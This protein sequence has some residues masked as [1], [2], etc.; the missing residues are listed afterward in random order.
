MVIFQNSKFKIIE[1]LIKPLSRTP[2]TGHRNKRIYVSDGIAIISVKKKSFIKFKFKSMIVE[3]DIF[4]IIEEYVYAIS[5]GC[6]KIIS[7]DA[8]YDDQS[9]NDN[10]K[11]IK[12]IL[13]W[14]QDDKNSLIS[15]QIN[16]DSIRKFE[17]IK[18]T[19]LGM[20]EPLKNLEYWSILLAKNLRY[21]F[22]EK[23]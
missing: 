5:F 13:E 14:D 8:T 20:Y 10:D 3:F 1:Y 21:Y 7:L 4:K 18:F 2:T 9:N 19:E 12:E 11:M 22:I 17:N 23:I 15:M 16:K 6:I